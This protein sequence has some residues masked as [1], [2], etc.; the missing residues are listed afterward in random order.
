MKIK[1][2]FNKGD[3]L[4]F[5]YPSKYASI[6]DYSTVVEAIIKVIHVTQKPERAIYLNRGYVVCIVKAIRGDFL[7][8]NIWVSGSAGEFSCE[9]TSLE[10]YTRLLTPTE[11]VLY[12]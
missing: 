8:T 2:K 11:K 9:S 1:T 5:K 12:G 10:T 7:S 6:K 4:Y 3:V